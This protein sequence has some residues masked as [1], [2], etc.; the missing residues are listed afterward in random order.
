MSIY[1][2]RIIGFCLP[3]GAIDG[4]RVPRPSV[5]ACQV[6]RRPLAQLIA[7]LAIRTSEDVFNYK[8][9]KTKMFP[10]LAYEKE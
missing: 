3:A 4:L 7:R 6:C 1:I 10:L 5:K 9:T 2:V 8:V